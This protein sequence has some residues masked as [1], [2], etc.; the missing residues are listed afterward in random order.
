MTCCQFQ[1]G[2]C[3]NY[4]QKYCSNTESP[5][6]WISQWLEWSFPAFPSEQIIVIEVSEVA[7]IQKDPYTYQY[8][9]VGLHF[10]WLSWLNQCF[11][12]D[13]YTWWCTSQWRPQ[14]LWVPSVR[15]T[16]SPSCPAWKKDDERS[17]IEDGC[18]GSLYHANTSQIIKCLVNDNWW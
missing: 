13:G 4:P 1:Q 5:K 17:E 9:L 6:S 18:R 2:L 12:L 14:I 15:N 10:G 3:F 7:P 11:W 8:I 16:A